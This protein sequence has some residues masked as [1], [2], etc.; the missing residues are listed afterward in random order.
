VLGNRDLRPEHGVSA[1]LGARLR[2]PLLQPPARA[3]LF[4][5]LFG[6]SRLASDLIAFR[7]K[8]SGVIAPYNVQEARVLGLELA[9]GASAF[10]HLRAELALTALDPRDTSA[11]Q[12]GE[13][14]LLPFHSRLV[15]APR[16]EVY[17]ELDG[18]LGI[19]RAALSAAA[20]Y[21][22]SSIA[23]PAGLV[24][25]PEQMPVDIELE[26]VALGRRLSAR[27]AIG[28]LFDVPDF[29]TVGLALPGRRAHATVEVW[30]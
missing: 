16:V 29:D 21:R 23:D 30:W 7:R 9:A 5:E 15:A 28:N 2:S 19:D 4:V 6:F 17:A 24:P 14:N 12:D 13:T 3:E 20:H 18:R 1:E 11:S 22:A 10:E 26:L 25:I 27:A 8:S